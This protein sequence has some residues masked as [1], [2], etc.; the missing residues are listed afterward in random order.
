MTRSVFWMILAMGGWAFGQDNLSNGTIAR[1]TSDP[2]SN[3]WYLFTEFST[4][5][6]PGEPY[7][8]S[9]L[10]T[11]ELQPAMPVPLTGDWRLLSGRSSNRRLAWSSR[12]KKFLRLATAFPLAQDGAE[13]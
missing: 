8:N 11:L 2:T 10:S 1:E 13:R 7:K 6:T 9:N 3:L 5:F 12:R 4:A